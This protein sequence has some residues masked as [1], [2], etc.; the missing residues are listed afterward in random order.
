VLKI[1]TLFESS[2]S[3][4]TQHCP[5]LD[6]GLPKATHSAHTHK[7]HT[8][9]HC[10]TFTPHS[11][12]TYPPIQSKK[13]GPDTTD[14]QHGT[15]QRKQPHQENGASGEGLFSS[16]HQGQVDHVA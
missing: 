14:S 4:Y 12:S 10:I 2:T 9:T 15:L 7:H 16:A 8:H 13:N 3:D 1:F 5:P 6:S 11:C